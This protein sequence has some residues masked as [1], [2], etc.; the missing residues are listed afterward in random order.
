MEPIA[1]VAPAAPKPAPD[2]SGLLARCQSGDR[3]AFRELFDRYQH[4]IY[5]IALHYT[6]DAPAAMEIAQ[7]VFI[8][9]FTGV[10]GFRGESSFETWLFRLA[11]NCCHDRYRKQR[12][13][14]ALEPGRADDRR[15][16]LSD[17]T[18]R[19]NMAEHV[20]FGVAGLPED[21]RMTVI[22]RYTESLSYE[23]I[24]VVLGCP[25]GTVASRLNRAHR[26]LAMRLEHLK[27]AR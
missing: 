13:L 19:E 21:L 2:T 17:R 25:A 5:S 24:A 10:A 15:E 12:K 11:V 22:L 9:L 26:E 18:E 6:A 20:R 1:T 23:Q 14:V 8:K 4:R 27:G 3:D 16:S 7:D